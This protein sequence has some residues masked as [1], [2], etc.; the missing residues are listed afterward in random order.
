MLCHPVTAICCAVVMMD[1][2]VCIDCCCCCC[3]QCELGRLQQ[4]CILFGTAMLGTSRVVTAQLLHCTYVMHMAAA[5]KSHN[6]VSCC[7]H[8][9]ANASRLNLQQV[10]NWHLAD[11]NL[12][13]QLY[14]PLCGIVQSPECSSNAASRS[15]NAT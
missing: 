6:H 14:C 12:Y 9:L 11:D 10:Q 5:F 15:C 4:A 7:E 3:I 8:S 13:L 2:E 1:P